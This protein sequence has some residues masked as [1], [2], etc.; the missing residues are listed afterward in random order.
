MKQLLLAVAG[1]ISISAGLLGSIYESLN[2]SQDDAKKCLM[3]SIA[4]GYVSTPPDHSSLIYDARQLSS[5]VKV[6]GIR[7]LI[8]LAKEYTATE[9][10]KKDYAKWRK[11]KLNPGTKTKLGLPK[12]GKM[13]DNAVDNKMDK[14]QHDKDYPE[15][16]IE[17]VKKRL[18]DFLRISA[19]VDFD[20]ELNGNVFVKPEYEKKSPWWKMCFR[21]GKEVVQAGREDAQKWLDELNGK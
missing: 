20:A 9:D 2:I 21:A 18:T 11:E 13:L 15:D 19:T 1:I 8:R 10:F 6:E 14:K 17:L 12:F 7:E 3:T 4:E 5:E 16:G